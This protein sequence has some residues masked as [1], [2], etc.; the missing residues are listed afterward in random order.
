MKSDNTLLISL[1]LTLSGLL[2]L[3][4]EALYSAGGSLHVESISFLNNY[5]ADRSLPAI[6]FDPAR[7]DWGLYQARELSYLIDWLDVQFIAFSARK[8][9]I[10]FYSL[11]SIIFLTLC[12][13]IQQY[14]GRLLFP[15][16]QS[17]IITILSLFFL[18]N[19][20]VSGNIFFRSSKHGCA[21]CFTLV[22]YLTLAILTGKGKKYWKW[23]IAGIALGLITATLFDRQGAFF[24]AAYTSAAG[25]LLF[26]IS[27]QQDGK[28]SNILSIRTVTTVIL[29]GIA[30]LI[31]GTIYNLYIAPACILS[32]NGYTPSFDYQNISNLFSLKTLFP[33]LF[34]MAGNIGFT[35][36]NSTGNTSFFLGLL[37]L[38][39]LIFVFCRTAYLRKDYFWTVAAGGVLLLLG[40]IWICSSGMYAR[41]PAILQ[42]DVMY[43]Y[44]FL[45][46]MA[47]LIPVFLLA[48][49]AIRQTGFRRN[50][51]GILLSL[52]LLIHTGKYIGPYEVGLFEGS[53]RPVNL[54]LPMLRKAILEPD[55]D[56]RNSTMPYQMEHFIEY[57]RKERRT[58]KNSP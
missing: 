15:K 34:F 48:A 31:F 14:G 57:I 53:M 23:Q 16:L 27:G 3:V 17:W 46:V 18:L 37:L 6:I 4:L 56:Y 49:E 47:L 36:N 8:G 54:R 12:V 45:P 58:E 11:S 29:S 32:L 51:V 40:G 2:I 20:C 21:L 1:L 33:G 22:I 43:G 30:I 5:L 35:F 39:G 55:Y 28:Y 52:A 7:N 24:T 9:V 26:V 13:F 50:P 42:P 25:L 10:H 41:H 38:S 44:Y 19:P